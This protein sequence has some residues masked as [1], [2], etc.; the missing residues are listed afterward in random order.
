MAAGGSASYVNGGLSVARSCVPTDTRLRCRH[1]FWC[2]LS[3]GR[4]G[5]HIFE[6]LYNCDTLKDR[7]VRL[8][9]CPSALVSAD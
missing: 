4:Q 8:G 9:L 7:K 6:R 5:Y 2:S 3:C 1:R